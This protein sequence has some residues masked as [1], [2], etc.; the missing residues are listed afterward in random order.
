MGVGTSQSMGCF[1]KRQVSELRSLRDQLMTT[2][3]RDAM[4]ARL[5][6]L[7]NKKEVGGDADFYH[8]I[9]SKSPNSPESLRHDMTTTKSMVLATKLKNTTD[10]TWPVFE[11]PGYLDVVGRDNVYITI[12][13]TKRVFSPPKSMHRP[14]S[15]QSFFPSREMKLKPLQREMSSHK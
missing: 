2:S 7:S 4:N 14:Q 15:D 12:S 5:F 11:T 3:G 9:A 8:T 10:Q 6:M 13:D 1:C